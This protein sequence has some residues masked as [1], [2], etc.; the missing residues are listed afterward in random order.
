MAVG[1]ATN[2]GKERAT[3]KTTETS[4]ISKLLNPGFEAGHESDAMTPA[5]DRINSSTMQEVEEA[6]WTKLVRIEV[7]D[8]KLGTST[9]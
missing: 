8:Q 7:D 4:K 5:L 2:T 9:S 1:F 3:K 6:P